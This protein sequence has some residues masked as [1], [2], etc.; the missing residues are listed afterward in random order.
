MSSEYVPVN[1]NNWTGDHFSLETLLNTS[2]ANRQGTH[3]CFWHISFQSD[4]CMHS[5]YEVL[6][7]EKVVVVWLLDRTSGRNSPKLGGS[8]NPGITGATLHCLLLLII[9]KAVLET[10]TGIHTRWTP[11]SAWRVPR[12]S[13]QTTSPT[14]NH[15]VKLSNYTHMNPEIKC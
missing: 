4:K 14:T 9:N 8:V 6:E 10:F 3:S 11:I 1:W 13:V 15:G 12:G 5:C 7:E 2:A